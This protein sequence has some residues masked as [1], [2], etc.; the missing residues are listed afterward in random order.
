MNSTSEITYLQIFSSTALFGRW[1]IQ[2]FVVFFAETGSQDVPP[3]P[4]Y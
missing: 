4:E 1:G 3:I 2:D